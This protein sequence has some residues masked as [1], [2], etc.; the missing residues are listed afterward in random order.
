M[1]TLSIKSEVLVGRPEMAPNGLSMNSMSYAIISYNVYSMR[2]SLRRE[3]GSN[4]HAFPALASNVTLLKSV[5][6]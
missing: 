4:G 2:F 6:F 5:M 3:R 1:L